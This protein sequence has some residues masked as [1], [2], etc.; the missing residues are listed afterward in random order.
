MRFNDI[1]E[2]MKLHDQT[3]II[4]AF[5]HVGDKGD[6]YDYSRFVNV[7]S[8]HIDAYMYPIRFGFKLNNDNVVL[9]N[10]FFATLILEED[11]IS[12]YIAFTPNHYEEFIS[13]IEMHLEN[14]K[15]QSPDMTEEYIKEMDEFADVLK[16]KRFIAKEMRNC[17]YNNCL[18]FE[19]NRTLYTN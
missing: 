19:F 14:F 8:E 13:K 11:V 6:L 15:K 7:N 18:Y 2:R 12:L 1:V 17:F 10:Q 9:M 3:G 16:E 5:V 4:D